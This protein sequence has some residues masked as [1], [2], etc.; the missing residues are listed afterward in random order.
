MKR[1]Y[2]LGISL[3]LIQ[4]LSVMAKE[5]QLGGDTIGIQITYDGVMVSGT[6]TLENNGVTYNPA[7]SDILAGDLI[8]A[9][10]GTT[11]TSIKDLSRQ[12][13][14]AADKQEAV[15]TIL[16][17]GALIERTLHIEMVNSQI[18]TGLLIKDETLGIGTLTYIDPENETFASLGHEILDA[19][20][21]EPIQSD[22]G[23]IYAST[24]LSIRKAKPATAGV[25]N[26]Q[27]E[28]DKQQGTIAKVN[29]FGV[30]GFMAGNSTQPM[31][32]T[33]KQSDVHEGD[34]MI[35]TVLEGDV[36]EE[37]AIEITKVHMQQDQSIKGIEFKVIDEKCLNKTNG[38]VQGMSGSPIVQQNKLIGAVT[39]VA[40]NEPSHGYGIFIEWLM[41]ESDSLVNDKK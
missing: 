29:Q 19:D 31:I 37:I 12:L 25:K 20:T 3:L 4:P 28:F 8:Q 9:V 23:N 32:E 16:R 26:A 17:D 38:I 15:L 35:Y 6:Y 7:D 14:Q 22:Q 36:I 21:K 5:V 10:D 27:I 39:H 13:A 40:T 41:E 33:G 18:R 1:L 24:I 34:A 30:F 11:V 2:T